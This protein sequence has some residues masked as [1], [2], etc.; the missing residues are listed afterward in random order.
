MS[1]ED[2][3]QEPLWK[4]FSKKMEEK[5]LSPKNGGHFTVIDA[6]ERGMKYVE[7]AAGFPSEGNALKLFW[8]V[9]PADGI[10][11]DAKFHCFGQ[12]ALI[13]A[14][15]AAC[16]L[17]VGKNYDQAKRIGADLIDKR[18]RDKADISAFPEETIFVINLTLEAIEDATDHCAGIPLAA[19]YVSP[20]PQSE[21]SGGYPGWTSLSHAQK[22]SVLEQ[23]FNEEVRPYVELDEGGI[24]IQA[25]LN[26]REVIIAYQGN[27]TSCFSSIGATL[28]SIQQIIQTKIHP[29][30]VVVPNMDALNL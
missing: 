15:E 12:A 18:L 16:E 25:L 27:C 26:D 29:D 4:R 21:G 6:L 11:V 3:I 23:L 2:L 7:G 19:A 20:V 13:A 10:I 8:L 9:D 14:S 24:E 30:L 22:L 28:S 1:Y 17:V 5:I